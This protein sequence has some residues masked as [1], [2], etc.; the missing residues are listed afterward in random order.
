MLSTAWKLRVHVVVRLPVSGK[1]HIFHCYHLRQWISAARVRLSQGFARE[2]EGDLYEGRVYGAYIR[3]LQ[4]PKEAQLP[5]D[6]QRVLPHLE[7]PVD[8]LDRHLVICASRRQ[9]FA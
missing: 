5:D 4:K 2:A 6:P 8:V 9:R 1:Q 3:M 7:D